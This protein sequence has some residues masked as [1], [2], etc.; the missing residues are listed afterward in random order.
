MEIKTGE[1]VVITGTTGSGK[2]TLLKQLSNGNGNMI[3]QNA[4]AQLL[5]STV[6]QEFEHADAKRIAEIVNWFGISHLLNESPDA[7]SGGQKQLVSLCSVLVDY[8]EMI[9]IDDIVSQLD[10]M[11]ARSFISLIE[12]LNMEYGITIVLV[13][14]ALDIVLR[15]NCRVIFMDDKKILFDERDM[16]TL[17]KKLYA[18][19]KFRPLI[20]DVPRASLFYNLNEICMTPNELHKHNLKSQIKFREAKSFEKVELH[21]VFYSYKSTNDKSFPIQNMSVTFDK[22]VTCLIGANGSGKS[23]LLKLIAGIIKPWSGKLKTSSK[24]IRYLPQNVL[25]LSSDL[26]ISPGERQ[27]TAL[28]NILHGEIILLDEPTHCLDR[29]MVNELTK[30]ITTTDACIIIATH[31]VEFISRVADDCVVLLNGNA[32][33]LSVAEFFAGNRFYTTQLNKAMNV[34]SFEELVAD[35]GDA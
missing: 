34:L 15:L 33:K 11:T 2:S 14:Q 27:F 5:M 21:N 9:L 31:D 28:Q 23:T 19:P 35:E 29:I 8:P 12:M 6:M 24:L 17:F 7:L 1:F 18:I 10:I 3:L 20:P 13:T 16:K 22:R 32:F 26:N 30:Q 25:S 4:D